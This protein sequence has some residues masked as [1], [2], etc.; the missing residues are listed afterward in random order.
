MRSEGTVTAST[1]TAGTPFQMVDR[2]ENDIAILIQ[3]IVLWK[4]GR[5]V[6]ASHRNDFGADGVGIVQRTGLI[7]P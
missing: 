4:Q 3:I 1:S 2:G 7:T 5:L 6:R